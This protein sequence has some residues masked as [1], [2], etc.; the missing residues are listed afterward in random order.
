MTEADDENQAMR[1]TERVDGLVSTPST[2]SENEADPTIQQLLN[3]I[4][5]TRSEMAS[6]R[7]ENERLRS[8][9]EGLTPLSSHLKQAVVPHQIRFDTITSVNLFKSNV[10][11]T[12]KGH[13]SKQKNKQPMGHP[14]R[15]AP[16]PIGP[17]PGYEHFQPEPQ[18]TEIQTHL[19]NRIRELEGLITRI[20][21]VPAP[22]RRNHP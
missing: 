16:N 21:G 10:S 7:S 13:T 17:P 22:P 2:G 6:I 11:F 3:E 15:R 19:E 5:A 12:N 9:V 1:T 8:T 20:P 14:V 18:V 4:K